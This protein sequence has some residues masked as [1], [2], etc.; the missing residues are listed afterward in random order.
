MTESSCGEIE[1]A[2]KNISQQQQAIYTEQQQEKAYQKRKDVANG[3]WRLLRDA[4]LRKPSSSGTPS[5]SIHRFTGYQLLSTVKDTSYI[6]TQLQPLLTQFDWNCALTLEQNLDRMEIAV[7]TLASCYPK[8][9]CLKVTHC[10]KQVDCDGWIA[11]L[12]KRCQPAVALVRFDTKTNEASDSGSSTAGTTVTTTISLLVQET[13]SLKTRYTF[14]AYPLNDSLLLFT[15]E[16]ND[17]P[18]LSLQDLVSHRR[19][20]GVDNTG[21]ICVWDSEKTL[22]YLL[23]NH[24]TDLESHVFLTNGNDSKHRSF[25]PPNESFRILELGTGMAGL[26]A[27]TLGMYLVQAAPAAALSFQNIR[28]HQIQVTLTDGNATG[29]H[30]NKINQYLM[31]TY[32]STLQRNNKNEET[33]PYH[34]LDV[35]CQQLLW[36]TDM[37]NPSTPLSSTSIPHPS[38]IVLISDC[39]HF[40]NFHASLAMTTLRNLCIGGI[41]IFCQPTRG[42]S[43]SNFCRLLDAVTTT[44]T[45]TTCGGSDDALVQWQWWEPSILQEKH[46]QAKVHYPTVYDESLHR[47][48]V[49]IMTKLRDMVEGDRLVLI[50]NHKRIQEEKQQRQQR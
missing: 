27:I 34:A 47:P 36:T 20:Q 44:T 35:T 28:K 42:D 7:L 29:V 6:L 10:P 26:S 4:L 22:T 25:Y 1:N 38:N 46:V 49:L 3:R 8:G 24:W 9:K 19:N 40:Q 18:R 13:S 16:P 33:S 15:R 45:S 21:N 11:T 50:Q 14:Q 2:V 41:A 17:H 5:C 37:E 12:A 39:V 23:W 43:L 48:K 30:N 32:N 31:E